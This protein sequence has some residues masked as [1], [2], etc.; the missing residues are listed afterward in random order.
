MTQIQLTA[1]TGYTP[2][3]VYVADYYGNNVTFVGQITSPAGPNPA[4]PTISFVVPSLFDGAPTIMIILNDAN[5]CQV[6]KL[7]DC[8]PALPIIALRTQ[9]F[10][11]ITTEA[12][13]FLIP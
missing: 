5:G 11:P 7:V 8:E 13:V 4:P 3:D 12:G 1:I 9:D 6:F 2:I 10:I